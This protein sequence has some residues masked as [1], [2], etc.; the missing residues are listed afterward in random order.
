MGAF[1]IVNA[2]RASATSVP[3]PVIENE[4]RNYRSQF[5]L[6]PFLV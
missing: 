1:S 5:T 3:K 2:L 4:D 6:D